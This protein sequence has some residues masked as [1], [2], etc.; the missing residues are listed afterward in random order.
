MVVSAVAV[1]MALAAMGFGIGPLVA[2]L[3]VVGVAIGF[4]CGVPHNVTSMFYL[5]DDAFR[6]GEYI[7]SGNY[8]GTVEGFS[9]RSVKLR[10][11]RGALSAVPIGVL[12][13]VQN[14]NHNSTID[15]LDGGRH[16]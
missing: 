8:K 7:Q 11:Q 14:Q 13:A 9:I 5:L 15:E 3:S 2:G 12:G 1:L 16:L 4:G 10:H 6:V